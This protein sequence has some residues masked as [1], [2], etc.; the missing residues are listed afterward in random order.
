MPKR[1]Y[2]MTDAE[3]QRRSEQAKRMHAQGLIGGPGRGQ[4]RK[5]KIRASGYISDKASQQTT[6][7]KLWRALAAGL[8]ESQPISIRAKSALAILKVE[9]DEAELALKEEVA[10]D[11]MSQNEL[12]DSIVGIL[13]KAFAQGV[14]LSLP[15]D[16]EAEEIDEEIVDVPELPPGE[17]DAA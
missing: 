9:H 3:R 15:I 11:A 16:G 8:D 6:R 5:P 14:P 1:T 17:E 12:L 10:Y 2:T 7:K 13:G 4:G